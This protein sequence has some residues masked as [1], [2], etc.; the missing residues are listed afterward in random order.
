MEKIGFCVEILIAHRVNMR[1]IFVFYL[2]IM[3]FQNVMVTARAYVIIVVANVVT[4]KGVD[5]A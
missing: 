2:P 5:Y 4:L 1:T 3:D